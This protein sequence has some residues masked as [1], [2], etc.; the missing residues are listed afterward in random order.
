ME[1]DDSSS[2]VVSKPCEARAADKG[3]VEADEILD[4]QKSVQF[5]RG[6]VLVGLFARGQTPDGACPEGG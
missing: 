3:G 4:L 1:D 5:V 2:P 6:T